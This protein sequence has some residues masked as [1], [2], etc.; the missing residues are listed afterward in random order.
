MIHSGVKFKLEDQSYPMPKHK[1]YTWNNTT[2]EF[3]FE[4][5][6]DSLAHAKKSIDQLLEYKFIIPTRKEDI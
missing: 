4:R 6:V 1:L 5:S 3:I 2:H